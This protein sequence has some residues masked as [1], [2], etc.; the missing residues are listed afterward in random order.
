[1][2]RKKSSKKL[3]LNPVSLFFS[4]ACVELSCVEHCSNVDFE[5]IMTNI[6]HLSG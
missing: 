5:F 3:I 6:N 2:C 4:A 1:M